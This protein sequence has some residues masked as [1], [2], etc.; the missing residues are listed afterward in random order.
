MHSRPLTGR[1]LCIVLNRFNRTNR[2]RHSGKPA[3][4]PMI[5]RSHILAVFAAIVLC[6]AVS[7]AADQ[8]AGRSQLRDWKL[9]SSCELKA[10]GE[11]ISAPGFAT[12]GW[13]SVEVPSTV[14]GVL[15]G[16]HSLPD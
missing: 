16:D 4:G 6:A 15:V 8:P 14:V 13:H 11:T 1:A 9:Q 7:F 3:G 12:T 10:T 5:A 2:I